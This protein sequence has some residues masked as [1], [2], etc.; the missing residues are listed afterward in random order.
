MKIRYQKQVIITF[1]IIIVSLVLILYKSPRTFEKI[2]GSE[3]HKNINKIY[4]SGNLP[5]GNTNMEVPNN[6]IS[7]IL[8]IFDSYKYRRR[9]AAPLSG[10]VVFTQLLTKSSKG[11]I[12]IE[13]RDSG[14]IRI[15]NNQIYKVLDADKKELFEKV[16]KALK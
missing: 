6:K 13:V 2:I 16:T 11:S 5:D 1:V 3:E 12:Y 10:N 9:I 7:E 8:T 14:Y 4:M 15:P